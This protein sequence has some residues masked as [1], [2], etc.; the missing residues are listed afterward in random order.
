MPTVPT[1]LFQ[2]AIVADHLEF[3]R[4][5]TGAKKDPRHPTQHALAHFPCLCSLRPCLSSLLAALLPPADTFGQ[6][7]RGSWVSLR[8]AHAA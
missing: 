2:A 5:V 1:V 3:Y 7:L 6:T 4:W 8:E